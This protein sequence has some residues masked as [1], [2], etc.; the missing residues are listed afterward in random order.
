MR[1][2]AELA[3][4]RLRQCVSSGSR[5][6]GGGG[7]LAVR[8]WAELAFATF[9]VIFFAVAVISAQGWSFDVKLFPL[10]VGYPMLVVSLLNL[11]STVRTMQKE[12]KEER[13]RPVPVAAADVV[14]SGEPA[15]GEIEEHQQA[16]RAAG[17][18][19]QAQTAEAADNRV[20]YQAMT[21]Q[22]ID[23]KVMASR[24]LGIILWMLGSFGIIWVVGLKFGIPFWMFLFLR[25]QSKEKIWVAL[26]LSIAGFLFLVGFFDRVV[27][28]PWPDS[29]LTHWFGWDVTF[30]DGWGFFLEYP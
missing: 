18:M 24:A 22:E 9:L 27:H 29:Q 19:P 6:S 11:A 1:K 3:F 28:V 10:A 23:P 30:W 12:A 25:F 7:R 8:K 26:V 17:D 21:Q 15:P 20:A 2:W 16:Q 5:G 13:A 4:A 14:E